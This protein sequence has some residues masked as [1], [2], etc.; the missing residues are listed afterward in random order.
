MNRVGVAQQVNLVPILLLEGPHQFETTLGEIEQHG[1]PGGVELGIGDRLWEAKRGADGGTEFLGGDLAG[2]EI[3]DDLRVV[4]LG[5]GG[6][7]CGTQGF[8]PL[9]SCG[10]VQ[11]E[12]HV[13]QV[14]NQ[15]FQGHFWSWLKE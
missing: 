6:E 5:E 15:C 8:E 4:V 9:G 2:F 12:E 10:L 1:I 14:E 11:A 7:V 13:T 3:D